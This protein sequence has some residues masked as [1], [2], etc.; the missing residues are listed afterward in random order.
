MSVLHNLKR[1]LPFFML[2]VIFNC[3]FTQINAQKLKPLAQ[4]VKDAKVS[5]NFA[6]VKPF[7]PIIAVRDGNGPM[8]YSN[9]LKEETIVNLNERELDD[10]NTNTSGA[11]TLTLPFKNQLIDLELVEMNHLSDD[12]KVKTS[13]S[14]DNA[15]AIST[16]RFFRGIVKGDNESAVAISVFE[17]EL[18]GHITSGSL[19]NLVVNK[20]PN[21]NDGNAYLI[22]GDNDML[23]KND[24]QCETADAD[25]EH[26]KSVSL[27]TRGVDSV[28][29][30]KKIRVYYECD[31]DLFL[32]KNSSVANVVNYVAGAFNNVAT[33]YMN[34]GITLTMSEVFVWTSASPYSRTSSSQALSSFASSRSGVNADLG[35]LL[36]Y[37][38]NAK[39]G[40]AFVGTLCYRSF[41]FSYANIFDTYE[42]FPT[43]SWTI[44]VMAHELG[45]NLGSQHTQWCG[46]P[47]GPIDNCVK[48]E[49]TCSPGPN[50]IGGGTIMSYC[51]SNQY[52]VNFS[53]GLGPLPGNVIRTF[54]NNATCLTAP[55]VCSAPTL[56]TVS[57]VG[58]DKAQ[59]SWTPVTNAISYKV[60]YKKATEN[61]WKSVLSTQSYVV[62][63]NLAIYD[64]FQVRIYTVCSS[65]LSSVSPAKG[66]RTLN[67]LLC[68][69][70]QSPS[71][72]NVTTT[73]ATFKWLPVVGATRYKLEY[74][75]D[76]M[77]SWKNAYTTETTY[78]L[79][80][81]SPSKNFEVRIT[82]TCTDITGLSS[83]ITSFSTLGETTVI[84]EKTNK[85]CNP[86]VITSVEKIS[87]DDAM[88]SWKNSLGATS[89]K[90][91]YKKADAVE[92]QSTTAPSNTIN[93]TNLSA[94][95]PYSVRVSAVCTAATGNPSAEVTFSTREASPRMCY[96]GRTNSRND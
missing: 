60:E 45:H 84:G 90:L 31:Y 82:A 96:H 48:Q 67:N 68:G 32:N 9:Y 38:G 93:L 21:K 28:G 59:V 20:T 51:M 70:E 88:V 2:T 35:Q 19:G 33:I 44:M 83:P 62:L 85:K 81:L 8:Q 54:V 41:K 13:A 43:Y 89:Y 92:W 75:V 39:G 50:P 1:A 7:T 40:L 53:K 95:T 23:I 57:N 72:S 12:F 86:T 71:V 18:V 79:N 78:S 94:S 87:T 34:E 37:G 56:P 77:L 30:D 3:T 25:S 24:F 11:L 61:A 52:G 29:S 10:L 74:R 69:E 80:N 42:A 17:D 6:A 66:F 26:S 14:G 65:G 36:T 76:D 58:L 15:V 27:S 16:G 64:S 91:E 73:S 4:L 47:G 63:N 55:V 5:R 22:Y 49:G 46:W